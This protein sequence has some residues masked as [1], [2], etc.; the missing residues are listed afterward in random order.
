[1]IRDRLSR[2]LIL[3][4][5][6]HRLTR[7]TLHPADEKRA[8]HSG[9]V[10]E[11]DTLGSLVRKTCHLSEAAPPNTSTLSLF[12]E[13]LR[14]DTLC[15]LRPQAAPPSPLRLQDHSANHSGSI[16]LGSYA[17]AESIHGVE[18]C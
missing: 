5:R 2:D 11:E 15:Y 18:H 13:Q 14:L 7:D 1:M 9:A 4:S 16:F 8:V 10:P 17:L 3:P 12:A 6:L